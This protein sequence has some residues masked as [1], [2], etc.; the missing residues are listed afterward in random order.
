M[1]SSGDLVASDRALI[2]EGKVLKPGDVLWTH[3]ATEDARLCDEH[4]CQCLDDYNEDDDFDRTDDDY[5]ASY[6]NDTSYDKDDGLYDS[7]DGPPSPAPAAP[8]TLTTTCDGAPAQPEYPCT[9]AQ[10]N[11]FLRS[12]GSLNTNGC[13]LVSYLA[14]QNCGPSD[15]STWSCS[16][17]SSR[18]PQYVWSCTDKGLTD[19]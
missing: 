1:L 17:D 13:T 8:T 12:Y 4:A 19:A 14:T 7:Y 18:R 16:Y 2:V 9:C 15:L 10:V 5:D 3:L 11:A 6:D